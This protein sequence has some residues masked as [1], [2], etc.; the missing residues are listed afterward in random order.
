MVV[1]RIKATKEFNYH[2]ISEWFGMEASIEPNED[3][4]EQELLLRAKLVQVFKAV[5]AEKEPVVINK[6]KISPEISLEDA[7]N[8]CNEVKV[9]ESYKLIV[10]NN[11]KLN[12]IYRNKLIELSNK[13]YK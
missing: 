6:E 13:S 5:L 8:S 10:R 7:I 2:G 4:I 11:D 12:T 3:P 1:D 9:L